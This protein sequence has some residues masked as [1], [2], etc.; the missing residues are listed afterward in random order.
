M[1]GIV[2]V[3]SRQ[4]LGEHQECCRLLRTLTHRG[5]DERW[6]SSYRHLGYGSTRLAIVDSSVP[7]SPSTESDSIDVLFN[8]EI[9]NYRDLAE[10]YGVAQPISERKVLQ[11][12]YQKLGRNF[13]AHLN[14]VFALVVV[15]KVRQEVH[16]YRDPV[17]VKP[18]FYWTDPTG[19]ALVFSSDVKTICQS[20][21]FRPVINRDYLANEF[22]LGFTDYDE[23]LFE[24]IRQIKPGSCLTL[25]LQ[26]DSVDMTL[27]DYESLPSRRQRGEWAEDHHLAVLQKAV[28]LQFRHCEHFPIGLLLSG[29][30]DSSLLMFLA[31]SMGLK[32]LVCFYCGSETSP[33]YVWAHRVAAVAGYEIRHLHLSAPQIWRELAETCYAMSGTNSLLP[34]L[35]RQ[36]KTLYP[37]I[38]VLWSGEG[39]D[40]LFGGYPC[41]GDATQ[42][43]A[44][45][46]EKIAQVG[47]STALLRRVERIWTEDLNNLE[48]RTEVF[49][50]YQEEQLVNAH[51]VAHDYGGMACSLEIRL[52]FLDLANVGLAGNIPSNEVLGLE[53]KGI[54]K[55]FLRKIS[56]IP[57]E[58][59]YHREKLG[60]LH[61]YIGVVHELRRMAGEMELQQSWAGNEGAFSK[62]PFQRFWYELVRRVFVDTRSSHPVG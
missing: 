46:E 25:S 60:L 35:C 5:P 12:L 15:D 51:L 4:G 11:A 29:G 39:A 19:E 34:H 3:W 53:R 41:H 21:P 22:V 47:H 56:G 55:K 28:Y 1:C 52:P 44:S 37:G 9:W 13:A 24:G 43:L 2:G 62:G 26:D 58:A 31:S 18:I 6:I 45:W 23:N 27:S 61:G 42:L 32:D 48:Q 8:G 14:G 20:K 10:R 17:G 30:I 36:I 50:L 59:F 33:D 57:D 7:L 54:L 38:K 40:E 16:L 49:R